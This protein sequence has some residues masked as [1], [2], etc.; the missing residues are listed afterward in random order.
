MAQ[1]NHASFVIFR[2]GCRYALA[3]YRYAIVVGWL[4][5]LMF[6]ILMLF[7]QTENVFT[8]IVAELAILQIHFICFCSI[9]FAS[10]DLVW[11][12]ILLLIRRN[13]PLIP[14]VSTYSVFIRSLVNTA[15]IFSLSASF[16]IWTVISLTHCASFGVGVL[17]LKVCFT[18]D[19]G[20]GF[21]LDSVESQPLCAMTAAIAA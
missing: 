3:T 5:I 4:A 21:L 10:S 6:F 7:A 14:C 19:V 9:F 16:K 13:T 15:F 11:I 18:L 1:R 20:R 12:L 2:L 8:S 17:S